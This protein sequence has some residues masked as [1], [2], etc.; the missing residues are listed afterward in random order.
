MENYRFKI[1]DMISSNCGD[2]GLVLNVG[3]RPDDD[4]TGK[5]GVYVLWAKESLSYWMHINEPTIQLYADINKEVK[6]EC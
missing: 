2:Y 4:G 1:G 5:I 3:P 6:H